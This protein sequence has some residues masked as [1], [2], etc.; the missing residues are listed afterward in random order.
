MQTEGLEENFT[1]GL[2]ALLAGDFAMLT[3]DMKLNKVAPPG[4]INSGKSKG[5]LGLPTNFILYLRFR[6]FLPTL[7]GIR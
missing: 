6:F 3:P 5:S 1:L 4:W 2:A 7:R